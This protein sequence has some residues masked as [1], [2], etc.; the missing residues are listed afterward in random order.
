MTSAVLD[1][2]VFIDARGS[3]ESA[4]H[5]AHHILNSVLNGDL[6]AAVSVETVQEVFHLMLRRLGD[7]SAA[8][9]YSRWV[10]SSYELI[11]TDRPLVEAALDEL[12]VSDSIGGVDAIILAGA[13]RLG[14]DAIIT[15]DKGLGRAAGELWIDSS[16]PRAV[17]ALLGSA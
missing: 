13:R 2:T 1:T 5:G 12:A 11:E 4:R 10:A 14:A 3:D 9:S 16:D 17:S 7:R 6:Q 8:V 15:R